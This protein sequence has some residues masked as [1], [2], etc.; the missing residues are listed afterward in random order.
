MVSWM[1]KRGD[2]PT[3]M[4]EILAAAMKVMM[5]SGLG[6]EMKATHSPFLTPNAS[7]ARAVRLTASAN[8]AQVMRCA[9]KTIASASGLSKAHLST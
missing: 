6:F 4:A 2:K 1:E 7:K 3:Q 5:N 8:C 9:P